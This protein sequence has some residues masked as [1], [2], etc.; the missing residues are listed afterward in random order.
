[1]E[2]ERLIG[3]IEEQARNF[4]SRLVRIET[5]MDQLLEFKWKLIGMAVIGAFVATIFVE[6]MKG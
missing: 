5:K 4:E 6:W 2:F 3:K 1:M